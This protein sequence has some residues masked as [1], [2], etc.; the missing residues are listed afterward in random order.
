MYKY[1]S[2]P[3][4]DLDQDGDMGIWVGKAPMADEHIILTENG[5]Q[6]SEIVASRATRRKIRDQ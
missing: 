3:T 4:D 6:K 2:V 1:T 5:I